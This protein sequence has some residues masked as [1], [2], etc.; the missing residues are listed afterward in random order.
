MTYCSL[1]FTVNHGGSLFLHGHLT[2]EVTSQPGAAAHL[3]TYKEF[4]SGTVGTAI[5][6]H[7]LDTNVAEAIRPGEKRH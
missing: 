4:I 1:K 7:D 5:V 6:S 3:R 2:S